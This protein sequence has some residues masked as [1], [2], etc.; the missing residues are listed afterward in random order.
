M[1]NQMTDQEKA[2]QNLE[3]MIDWYRQ[4]PAAPVAY[5]LRTNHFTCRL[6]DDKATRDREIRA[7]GACKKIFT[8]DELQLVVD[9]NRSTDKYGIG[10]GFEI[11][12]YA[13]RASVC[14]ATVVGQREVPE[15]VIP[16]QVIPAHVED[17]IAWDC[18]PLLAT[19]ES[20]EA[21]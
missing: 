18:E 5:A 7:I 21:Q 20:E 14:T 16:E 2:I 13:T 8:D 19:P 1:T 9:V 15:Q 10:A 3:A 6:S 11:E 17:I 12:F 4:H